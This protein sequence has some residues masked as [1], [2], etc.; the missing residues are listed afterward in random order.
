MKEP[1]PPARL[2][3]EGST[4]SES[5]PSGSRGNY[6]SGRESFFGV[7]TQAQVYLSG[8]RLVHN[9]KVTHQVSDLASQIEINRRNFLHH[10]DVNFALLDLKRITSSFSQRVQGWEGEAARREREKKTMSGGALAKM[11]SEFSMVRTKI[12]LASRTLSKLEIELHQIVGQEAAKQRR[13]NSNDPPTIHVTAAEP[14]V[15]DP[16]PEELARAVQASQALNR[17][18]AEWTGDSLIVAYEQANLAIDETRDHVEQVWDPPSGNGPAL[19]VVAGWTVT[20]PF[21]DGIN[22]ERK[23]LDFR[24]WLIPKSLV[25]SQVL[26]HPS[27]P[28]ELGV[29]SRKLDSVVIGFRNVTENDLPKSDLIASFLAKFSAKYETDP[30]ILSAYLSDL[31]WVQRSVILKHRPD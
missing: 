17:F 3:E 13:A 22:T 1:E 21:A 16:T 7:F 23:R 10:G 20:R 31:E 19:L 12:R 9:E 25:A 24:L 26:S 4:P 5:S 30:V 27:A 28:M 6:Y 11:K 29:T 15:P 18:L 8:V 2:S 14:D